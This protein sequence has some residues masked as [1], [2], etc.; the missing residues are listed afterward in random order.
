V[1]SVRGKEVF[2]GMGDNQFG[3]GVG[4]DFFPRWLLRQIIGAAW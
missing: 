3:G 2:H 4:H 1:A